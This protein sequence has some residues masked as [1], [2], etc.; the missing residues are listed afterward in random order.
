M[1]GTEIISL[2]VEIDSFTNL[3]LTVGVVEQ[4]FVTLQFVERSL[5]Q[6]GGCDINVALEDKF[7]IIAN[8]SRSNLDD[9][10]FFLTLVVSPC[11]LYTSD[12]ADE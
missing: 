7:T 12:A 6:L 1:I 4:H 2:Q 3:L 5:P 9:A 8:I 10:V 11:L